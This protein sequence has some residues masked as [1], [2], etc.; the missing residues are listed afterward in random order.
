MKPDFSLYNPDP[1]YLRE[2]VARTGLSQEKCA[3]QLGIA[4]RTFRYYLSTAA[5]HQDAP[6]AV[7]FS[8]E[9]LAGADSELARADQR[10]VDLLR[11]VGA[12]VKAAGGEVRVPRQVIAHLAPEDQIERNDDCSTGDIVFTFR[13][14]AEAAS[15]RSIG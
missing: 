12:I 5:D 3:K 4:P 8:L 6:Y 10:V 14:S 9:A 13:S 1:H 7:Q 2:L 15:S 11:T